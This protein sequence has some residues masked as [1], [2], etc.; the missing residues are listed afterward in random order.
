MITMSGLGD[1]VSSVHGSAERRSNITSQPSSSLTSRGAP[2]AAPLTPQQGMIAPML[3]PHRCAALCLSLAAC[4]PDAPPP[5]PA[6][7]SPPPSSP[8]PPAASSAASPQPPSNSPFSVVARSPDAFQLYPLK[9]ALFVDAAGFLAVLGE[10]PLHQSPAVMRGLEK[11]EAGRIAGAYPD[12]A[13]LVAADATYK[14]TNDRWAENKLLR[15]HETL[16]DV[17]AWGDN[18]AIA[19]IAMPGN[20]MRF[21]LAGGKPGVVMPAPYPADKAHVDAGGDEPAAPEGAEGEDNACKVKMKP[22]ELVMAGLPSGEF[23]VAGYACEPVGHGG[24]IVERWEPK[25]VRGTVEPLPEPE[26]GH[27]HP[28]LRGVL[29]RSPAEVLVYGAEGLPARPYLA[30][31]DGKTWS[32]DKAPFGAGIDTLAAAADG[33]LWAAAGGAVWKKTSAGAWESVPLPG[34]VTVQAVWPR[35]GADVW[36]SAR[37]GGSTPAGGVLLR[38]AK[39]DPAA[40]LPLPPRNAMSGMTSSNRRFFATA[41]CDKVYAHLYTLGASK[42]PVPKDFSAL[43][44]VFDGELAS[45]APIVEDDGAHLFVGVPVP[46]LEVGHELLAAY[47]EKNPKVT[48]NLF[49]HEPVIVKQAI[50]LGAAPPS[51]PLKAGKSP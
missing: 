10:G 49:C 47:H 40:A 15:E 21:V 45:L 30:R 34:G 29:A 51:S 3:R 19:V 18:R 31:F 17:A 1:G 37:E 41:A 27:T 20:D 46:S 39:I 12:G 44:P 38:T 14:W 50:T 24:A 25:Q 13:W 5:P 9:G 35:T 6:E 22:G 42:D 11:G 43:K 32:L 33:T 2:V 8:A 7:P 36:A 4:K 16:L 28:D 23:Y 48:S 26:S